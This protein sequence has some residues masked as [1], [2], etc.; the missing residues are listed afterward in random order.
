MSKKRLIGDIKE[1]KAALP[2]KNKEM[3]QKKHLQFFAG[4]V[5]G[6][7]VAVLLMMIFIISWIYYLK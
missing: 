6:F 4:F 1:G 7:V 5:V 2:F 3:I